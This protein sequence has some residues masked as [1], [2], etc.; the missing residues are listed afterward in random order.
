MKV[1]L[2][3][4]VYRT[5]VR[6][7]YEI[8]LKE[9]I[10]KIIK[11][12][13]HHEIKDCFSVVVAMEL[14]AHLNNQYDKNF[15]ECYNGLYILSH[16]LGIVNKG[17]FFFNNNFIAAIDD[18]LEAYI[19]GDYN[20]KRKFF[21]HSLQKL[22]FELTKDYNP[23][24]CNVFLSDINKVMVENNEI[25]IEVEE[26][27]KSYF[28]NEVKSQRNKLK[29]ELSSNETAIRKCGEDL[30]MRYLRRKGIQNI[31]QVP[32]DFVEKF[33]SDYKPSL[34]MN[35]KMLERVR[36]SQKDT[37]WDY[38]RKAYNTIHDIQILFALAQVGYKNVVFISNDE[39]LINAISKSSCGM[40][41]LCPI[42]YL[43]K[44]NSN[45]ALA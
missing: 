2:D 17:E 24:T 16:H 41:V 7:K 38:H 13:K 3:T 20:H 39:P 22:I 11:Y 44:I 23:I 12:Q 32:N 8:E 4:N 25:K 30:L 9:Q 21:Y 36:D 43:E 1:L 29:V 15:Y 33:I 37:N 6:N 31:N 18:L 40:T 34:E 28:Q 27:I 19:E 42:S 35:I 10:D 5:I 26:N 45:T 14:I